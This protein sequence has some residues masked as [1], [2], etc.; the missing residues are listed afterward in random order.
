MTWVYKRANRLLQL[1]PWADITLAREPLII[2]CEQAIEGREVTPFPTLYVESLQ[3]FKEG[4]NPTILRHVD[5]E[6]AFYDVVMHLFR[7][8]ID[9]VR[10]ADATREMRIYFFNDRYWESKEQT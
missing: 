9:D 7:T 2:K 6:S 3:G 10:W 8:F 4:L 1:A 5:F